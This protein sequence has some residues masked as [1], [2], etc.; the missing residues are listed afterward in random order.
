MKLFYIWKNKE[1]V[2]LEE[3]L[4]FY[5]HACEVMRGSPHVQSVQSFVIE[6]PEGKVDYQMIDIIEVASWEA[7]E[8]EMERP[9]HREIHEGF[10]GFAN[11]DDMFC[12]REVPD[13]RLVHNGIVL[14][15]HA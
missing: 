15:T 10:S 7:W 6:D 5:A 1:G 2:E 14:D 11:D 4:A 13:R 9:E 8:T 12:L 3:F